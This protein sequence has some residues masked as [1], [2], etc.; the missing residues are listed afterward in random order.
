MPVSA[1]WLIKMAPWAKRFSSVGLLGALAYGC[2]YYKIG[3]YS[4]AQHVQRIWQTSEA[5]DLREGISGKL[6]GAKKAAL[7]ELKER[8]EAS[9][10]SD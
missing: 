6:G 2:L 5:V 1:V 10:T 7:E 3:E 8:L 9:K 4:L